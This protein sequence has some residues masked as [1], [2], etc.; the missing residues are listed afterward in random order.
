MEN[1]I[2][3]ILDA[4]NSAVQADDTE[5]NISLMQ[6]LAGLTLCNFYTGRYLNDPHYTRKGHEYC[7]LLIHTINNNTYKLHNLFSF[8]NGL[9]G[10]CY[11]FCHLNEK[12]F[13]SFDIND[14]FGD[15]EEF[16][17]NIGLKSL[18]VGKS[19]YLHG[20][21]GILYYFI[22]RL[23]EEKMLPWILQMLTAYQEKARIDD[24]GMRMMNTVLLGREEIEFDLGLAHGLAGQLMILA[25][26]K[27]KG[28]AETQVSYLIE[29]GMRFIE[30]KR[31]PLEVTG[32]NSYY[33]TSYIEMDNMAE[34]NLDFYTSRLA[35]CYG[36]LNQALMY[37]KMG[38]VLKNETYLANAREIAALTLTNDLYKTDKLNL[39]FCH[40]YSGLINVYDTIY[41]ATGEQVYKDAS[42][43]WADTLLQKLDAHPP[44][45]WANDSN[46]GLLEGR[47]GIVLSLLT[48]QVPEAAGWND[49]FLLNF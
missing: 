19:D 14:G 26:L 13:L 47:A 23:P 3:Q 10:V 49:I 36:D 29:Q 38:K 8:C 6:G 16:L 35:W 18:K 12:K 30:G 41:R 15:T 22:R 45:Q 21:M 5:R 2:R 17:F 1:R 28:I 9:A 43:S 39:F 32:K 25:E 4:L 20:G 27:E 33:P 46:A 40:G 11:M 48:A 31:Q 7:D 37:L 44:E 24:N 34:Q 42:L